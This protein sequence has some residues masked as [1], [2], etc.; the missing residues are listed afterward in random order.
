VRYPCSASEAQPLPRVGLRVVFFSFLVC[1]ASVSFSRP[2]PADDKKAE[3]PLAGT[4]VA[5]SGLVGEYRASME[6]LAQRL[7]A[8]LV[9]AV[10]RAALPDVLVAASVLAPKYK[11]SV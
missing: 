11:V 6:A 10:T 7:G 1:R 3:K 4:R 8:T 2:M 9:S 5:V